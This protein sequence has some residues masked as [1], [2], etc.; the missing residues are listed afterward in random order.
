M[1]LLISLAA[2][3]VTV[4]VTRTFFAIWLARRPG[5]RPSGSTPGL[6]ARREY[7][8]IGLRRWAYGLT[9]AF[10]VPGLILLLLGA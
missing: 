7:D 4:F 10:V 9:A 3:M 8:V 6:L 1:T 2:S 5:S